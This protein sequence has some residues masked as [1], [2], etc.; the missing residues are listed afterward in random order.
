[1]VLNGKNTSKLNE[2]F[3]KS[4]D[5]NSDIGFILEA[6][7]EYPKRLHNLHNDL[8][9]LS[10]RMKIKKCNKLVCNLHDKNN[11][12]AHITT[13]KQALN[14]GLPL[15]RVH[16]IIQ[17][18]QKAWLKSYIDTNA[19]LRTEARNKFGKDFFKLM[20]NAIFG[21]T[22]ENVR[23]HRNIKLITTNRRRN[24][25]VSEPNYRTTKRF[26]KNLLALQMKKIKVKMNKP[27]YLG[28]SIL[29]ISKTVMYEFM[30]ILNQGINTMLKYAT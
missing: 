20:N 25:L 18:N 6:D 24:F 12:V 19:K 10:E 11:Y 2:K 15:K 26:P 3:I 8:P 27:L 28:L 29:E 16:K 21:K 17:F 22:M 7:V 13:L 30:I 14:H 4:Y 9:F 1:M 5:E 23:K